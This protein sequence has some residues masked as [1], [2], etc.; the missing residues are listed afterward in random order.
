MAKLGHLQHLSLVFTG[1]EGIGD[2]G[3]AALGAGVAKLS[4]LKHF[5]LN[6]KRCNEIGD[7]KLSNLKHLSLDF[8][9][10]KRIYDQG[11]GALGAGVA[12]LGRE[13]RSWTRQKV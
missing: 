2:Q 10:C 12:K 1:C 3:V 13:R 9:E 4:N 5:S 7:P 6:F 8:T 11:V